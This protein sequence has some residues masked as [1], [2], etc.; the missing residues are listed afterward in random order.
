[1]STAWPRQRAAQATHASARLSMQ[2]KHSTPARSTSH[3]ALL[4]NHTDIAQDTCSELHVL[5]FKQTSC[6]GAS[7]VVREALPDMAG[8]TKL[9][10]TEFAVLMFTAQ[11]DSPVCNHSPLSLEPYRAEAVLMDPQQRLLLQ[12]AAEVLPALGSPAGAPAPRTA[13]LVGIGSVEY[14]GLAA[15]LGVSIYAATGAAPVLPPVLGRRRDSRRPVLPI[16]Q[17]QHLE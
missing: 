9:S 6:F 15:H 8:Q 5:N 11:E 10:Q 3:G 4:L 16:N 2:Q 7:M 13:V 1:M 17:G 12:Q 14:T